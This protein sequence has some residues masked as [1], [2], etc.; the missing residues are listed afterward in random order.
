MVK[1]T[2]TV[3]RQQPTNCSSAFNRFVGLMLNGLNW[4][5]CSGSKIVSLSYWCISFKYLNIVFVL[6]I[7]IN[8]SILSYLFN[9]YGV[10]V[11]CYLCSD[12][13]ISETRGRNN[14]WSTDMTGQILPFVRPEFSVIIEMTDPYFLKQL[15]KGLLKTP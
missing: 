4:F 11:A 1:H 7:V 15:E 10:L 3:R 6:N 8:K 14:G 5:N 12:S 2:E 9:N 13:R